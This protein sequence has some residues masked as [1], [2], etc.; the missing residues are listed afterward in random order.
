MIQLSLECSSYYKQKYRIVVV[1]T[2]V[3]L[4]A[5]LDIVSFKYEY[6]E[7]LSVINLN[8]KRCSMFHVF[9]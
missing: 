9:I 3:A 6:K 1:I 4:A 5:V 7:A 2:I 8:I